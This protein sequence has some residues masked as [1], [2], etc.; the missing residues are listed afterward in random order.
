MIKKLNIG[1]NEYEINTNAYT[2]F[3]YKK[4]FGKGI[5]EDISNIVNFGQE[6][7]RIRTELAKE[8]L[9]G[10]LLNQK[11]GIEIMKLSSFDS[12]LDVVLQITYIFIKNANEKFMS[13][14]SWLKTLETINISDKWF[15][16][17]TELAVNSFPR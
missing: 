15:T 14:E 2:R 5:L 10:E 7:D 4:E 8:G 17:V 9:K 12:Y 13:F 16:E 11:I 3:L 6:V 1:E